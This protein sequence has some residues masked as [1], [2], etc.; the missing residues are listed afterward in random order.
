MLK[1]ETPSWFYGDKRVDYGIHEVSVCPQTPPKGM[2]RRPF[3]YDDSWMYS[4]VGAISYIAE[5]VV[6]GK[7][8]ESRWR[9][10]GPQDIHLDDCTIRRRRHWLPNDVS[11]CYKAYPQFH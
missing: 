10:R 4:A 2:R 1:Y 9:K 3:R 7:L 8:S 11:A 6:P 5:S